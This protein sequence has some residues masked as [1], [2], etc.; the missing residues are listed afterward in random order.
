MR[1]YDEDMKLYRRE[2]AL[3]DAR[4]KGILDGI[5]RAEKDQDTEKSEALQASLDEIPDDSEPPLAPSIIASDPT[6][7]GLIKNLGMA[8]PSLGLFSS[9]GGTF[10]GGSGMNVENRLKTIAGF[11]KLWDA[12]PIDRW[13]AGDGISM[14]VGRRISIH[15]QVQPIAAVDLLA[16]PVAQEQD[17]WQGSLFPNQRAVSAT[18]LATACAT[19]QAMNAK[20]DEFCGERVGEIEMAAALEIRNG[21]RIGATNPASGRRRA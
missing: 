12:E 21:E 7:E 18:A 20:V 16:D 9:E 17:F 13:R 8:R 10:I 2:C 14:F 6:L 1:Q 5:K 19:P 4:R 11:S 3:L 15:I